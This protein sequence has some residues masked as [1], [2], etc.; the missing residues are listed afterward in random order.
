MIATG[1]TAMSQDTRVVKL[2]FLCGLTK[3]I[4]TDCG[5]FKILKINKANDVEVSAVAALSY[6]SDSWDRNYIAAGLTDGTIVILDKN[7]GKEI[8][9]IDRQGD[10]NDVKEVTSL[11][12]ITISK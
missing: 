5:D 8:Q 1:V 12:F 2:P 10:L 7:S 11:E 6:G 9:R 3:H 4:S